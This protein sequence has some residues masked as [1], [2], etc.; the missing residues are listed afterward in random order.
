[1]RLINQRLDDLLRGELPRD[2]IDLGILVAIHLNS[3]LLEQEECAQDRKKPNGS[4]F[5]PRF[6]QQSA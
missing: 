2:E 4:T 5:S 3:I 1:M 6:H